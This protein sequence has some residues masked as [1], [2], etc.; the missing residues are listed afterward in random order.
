VTFSVAA[1]SL[2]CASMPFDSGGNLPEVSVIIPTIGRPDLVVR[3]ARSALA[4]TMSDIEV[5]VIVDGPDP[6][7]AAA[8][9][10]IADPR[11]RVLTNPAPLHVGG[12]RNRGIDESISPWVAFLDD[13]DEWLPTKLER[14]L[15]LLA[16]DRTIAMAR[17][18]VV[19]PR[20]DYVWPRTIYD[21]RL[22]LD[23]YLFDR[24][25]WFKGDGFIQT[26]ALVLP[27]RLFQ[28][29]RFS[30]HRQHEDW[31]LMIRAVKQQGYRIVT[32][33]EPLVVHYAEHDRPSLSQRYPWRRSLE[34]L[35]A[36][37]GLI[38]PRAYSGFCLTI[39]APQPARYRQLD[40]FLPLLSRSLSRGA[41][42]MR[43]LA[44]YLALWLIPM[45]AR[46]AIR[47]LMSARR[48][49]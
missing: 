28:G 15:A 23:E 8:L 24:R 32:A 7:S 20:G 38:T 10:Q 14:Q 41:P 25:S 22:P 4:Q 6:A 49:A 33:P 9:A 47:R 19:T 18:L 21:N 17:S 11:L 2:G 34:W 1:H 44:M 45:R 46:H 5:I 12:T 29:L 42:T 48:A 37:G 16:D 31:E 39:L 35:D 40:A 30:D 27:R 43:Q 13:D 26:S 3:A 36:L